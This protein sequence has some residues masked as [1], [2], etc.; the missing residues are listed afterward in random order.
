MESM[1]TVNVPPALHAMSSE[2]SN[3][4]RTLEAQRL[5]ISEEQI[6]GVSLGDLLDGGAKLFA[7]GGAAA[8]EDPAGTYALSQ[9]VEQLDYFVSHA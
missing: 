7:D 4:A 6:R 9:P 5:G 3:L 1:K 2:A 8:R